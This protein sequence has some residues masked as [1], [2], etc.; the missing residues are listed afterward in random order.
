MAPQL[1]D[2]VCDLLDWIGDHGAASPNA[3]AEGIDLPRPTVYRLMRALERRGYLRRAPV[4]RGVSL[5]YRLI[6]LAEAAWEGYSVAATALPF[7][8]ELTARTEETCHLLVREGA[9]AVIIQRAESQRSVRVSY[10]P[11]RRIPLIR[12]ASAKVILAHLPADDRERVLDEHFASSES[13]GQRQ[14]LTKALEDIRRT[15]FA[16]TASEVFPD[17]AAVAIPLLIRGQ[18][19]CALS[20]N[21]PRSRFS[22]DQVPG[23]V[24]E[25]RRAAEAITQEFVGYARPSSAGVT[26]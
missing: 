20:L 5:G 24:S 7:M 19:P 4:S 2:R 11:G 12:G 17:V 14:G 1:I 21:L 22:A 15:G 26:Q 3:I 13:L 18:P 16:S 25:L 23:I 6:E 9:H 10:P 8:Q